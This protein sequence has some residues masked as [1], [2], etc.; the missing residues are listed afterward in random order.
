M[1]K[2]L[3]S[4]LGVL[5]KKQKKSKKGTVSSKLFADYSEEIYMN[6]GKLYKVNFFRGIFFGLGNVIGSTIVIAFII[7][8]LSQMGDLF[9]VFGDFI[10]RIIEYVSETR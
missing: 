8:V 2:S 7:W 10:K 5:K 1:K 9:P 4:K 6:R 3:K